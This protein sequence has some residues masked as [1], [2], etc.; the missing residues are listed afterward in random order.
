[1]G[2]C[3]DAEVGDWWEKAN[4]SI[5]IDEFCRYRYIIYTKVSSLP[6]SHL[7]QIFPFLHIF[8]MSYDQTS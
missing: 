1:M 6:T 8:P 4:N 5:P 3:R 7:T 2:G